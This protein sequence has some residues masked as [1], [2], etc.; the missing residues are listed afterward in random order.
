MRKTTIDAA[1]QFRRFVLPDGPEIRSVNRLGIPVILCAIF[2]SVLAG[3]ATATEPGTRTPFDLQGHRGARGLAPENTIPGFIRALELGV[4][5]LELDAVIGGDGEV[6]VSHEPWFSS[7]ICSHPDGR[8]VNEDEERDLKIFEMSY[9]QIVRFDFGSRGNTGFPGQQV[10]NVAKPLLTDVIRAVEA[11]VV[12][13]ESQRVF[14]N[15]EIKSTPERDGVHYSTVNEYAQLLV[16]VLNEQD[17]LS[18]TSIQSFDPRALEAVKTIDPTISLVFL[19][20]NDIGFSKNLDRLSFAPDIYSPHHLLVDKSLVE[21]VHRMD[22]KVIPWTVN[23]A[24][25]MNEL[26]DAGVDGFITDYP[27][28]GVA[29]L[30]TLSE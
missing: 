25:R 27:D 22:I 19:I 1:K 15:I 16:D 6:V 2:I 4:T 20:D 23:D 5:T 17:I 18:F 10:M 7:Q 13:L 21:A 24:E 12:S 26:I 9:D 11:H 8:P 29:L 3:C 14:Y 30:A 28:R